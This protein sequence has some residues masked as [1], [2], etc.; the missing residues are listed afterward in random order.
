MIGLLQ[1]SDLEEKEMLASSVKLDKINKL[2]LKQ[3]IDPSHYSRYF[4]TLSWQSS[5]STIVFLFIQ[6][7]ALAHT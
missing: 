3:N 4:D 7:A 2:G 1:I 6:I 5:G